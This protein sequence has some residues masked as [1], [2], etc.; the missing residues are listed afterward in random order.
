MSI[1]T[2]IQGKRIALVRRAGADAWR[3]GLPV[4]T[5]P[6]FT[7][8]ELQVEDA[9]SLLAHLATDD[10]SRF[11]SPPPSSIVGFERFIQVTH[12]D[13]EAGH[14]LCFAIAPAGTSL[15]SPDRFGLS[16]R[17]ANLA[18]GGVAGLVNGAVSLRKQALDGGPKLGSM[19]AVPG[20]LGLVVPAAQTAA[21]AAMVLGGALVSRLRGR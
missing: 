3:D 10:V 5:D 8:R 13:R 16:A 2:S 11:I 6:A 19:M 21:G 1:D 4:F 12:R 15:P 14:A 20:A 9:P 18:A 7:L 17:G